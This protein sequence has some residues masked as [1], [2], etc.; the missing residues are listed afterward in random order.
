MIRYATDTSN[1]Q[2]WQLEYR[3]GALYVSPRPA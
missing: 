2:E 3:Y 1:W